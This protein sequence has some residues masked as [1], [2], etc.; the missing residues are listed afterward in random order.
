MKISAREIDFGYGKEP[1]LKEACLD[2]YAGELVSIVGPNGTGKSTFIKC[3]N[4]LL[5]IRNGEILLEQQK[6]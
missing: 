3:I 2:V 5:G 6:H 1:I 4:R